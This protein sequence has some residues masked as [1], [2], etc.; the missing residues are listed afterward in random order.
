VQ[1]TGRAGRDGASAEAIMYYN[2]SDISKPTMTSEMAE[3]CKLKT[4][5]RQFL[6]SHF[7]N[8]YELK[9]DTLLHSC[10]DNCELQCQCSTC[11]LKHNVNNTDPSSDTSLTGDPELNIKL[12]YTLCAFVEAV[13]IQIQGT[14]IIDAALIT[15]LTTEIAHDISN[16][17]SVLE[18]IDA[19]AVVYK[20]IDIN[21]IEGIHQII[22][23]MFN[24][25]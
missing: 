12:K 18:H 15:G 2:A 25:E 16:N 9:S 7:G 10:C 22:T 11:V 3:F 14:S 24:S 4:C 8:S 5:R 21:Y 13:N 17:Y 23:Q 20:N 1:Q 6:A 19:L